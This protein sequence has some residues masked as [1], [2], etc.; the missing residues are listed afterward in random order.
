VAVATPADTLIKVMRFVASNGTAPAGTFDAAW[1]QEVAR[2]ADHP[3][4]RSSIRRMTRS[5]SI[6][7]EPEANLPANF[8][9]NAPLSP[10]VG[11]DSLWFDGKAGSSAIDTYRDVIEESGSNLAG[12]LDRRKEALFIVEERT[13][14]ADRTSSDAL[15]SRGPV[16]T[17]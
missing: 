13:I 9:A 2:I 14:V 12:L 10:Y 11:V 7:G 4:L 8:V 3:D 6:A 16:E 17:V 5:I 1:S 15:G